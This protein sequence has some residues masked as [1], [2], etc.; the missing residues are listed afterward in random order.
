MGKAEST[1]KWWEMH[2][3]RVVTE[4][5]AIDVLLEMERSTAAVL[6]SVGNGERLFCTGRC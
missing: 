4:E 3:V 2:A 6:K 1:W 5:L